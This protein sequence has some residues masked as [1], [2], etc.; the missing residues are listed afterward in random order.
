LRRTVGVQGVKKYKAKE[1]VVLV[2]SMKKE[3]EE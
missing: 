3:V 2:H 1:K